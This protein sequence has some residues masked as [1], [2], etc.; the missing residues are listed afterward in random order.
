[1]R[2]GA[3]GIFISIFSDKETGSELSNVL[4]VI[5]LGPRTQVCVTPNATSL[6]KDAR[7]SV[8]FAF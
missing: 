5:L 3:G 1:M 6:S 2:G 8:P 7:L 4:K